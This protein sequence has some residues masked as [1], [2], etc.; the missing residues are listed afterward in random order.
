[1]KKGR[2][3]KKIKFYLV[4][5]RCEQGGYSVECVPTE[6]V[7]MKHKQPLICRHG[8][9]DALPHRCAEMINE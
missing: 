3:N 1:M 4:R 7:C 5:K 6:D 9:E 8:C 2:K